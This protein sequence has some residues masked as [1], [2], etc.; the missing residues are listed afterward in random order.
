MRFSAQN[1]RPGLFSMCNVQLCI[2]LGL[3]DLKNNA[4]ELAKCAA[5]LFLRT[6]CQN[7]EYSIAEVLLFYFF[8]SFVRKSLIFWVKIFFLRFV[9]KN[10]WT[11]LPSFFDIFTS[12]GVK[13]ICTLFREIE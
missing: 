3:S 10:K 12:F 6:G 5:G 4:I 8:S 9:S 13:N 11:L 1:V 2:A 7:R